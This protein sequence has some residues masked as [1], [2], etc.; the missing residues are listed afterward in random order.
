MQKIIP[1]T[2][3]LSV[4]CILL[5]IPSQSSTAQTGLWSDP[6]PLSEL[7]GEEVTIASAP[8]LAVDH[9]G[10]LH[11]VWHGVTIEVVVD[12]DGNEQPPQNRDWLRYRARRAG[13]WTG[14]QNVF[15]R[16]RPTLGDAFFTQSGGAGMYNPAFTLRGQLLAGNDSHLHLLV[17]NAGRQWYL[18]APLNDE[19]VR[20]L[21]L[22][23][24]WPL[25]EG[26]QSAITISPEGKLYLVINDTPP[27]L[28]TIAD[29]PEDIC[30]D[31][32]YVFFRYS[33]DGGRI[34]SNTENISDD[35][36][37]QVFTPQ[38]KIDT[39][40]RLHVIWEERERERALDPGGQIVYQYSDDAGQRWQAPVRMALTGETV[41]QAAL[42][43]NRLQT[44]MVV[45]Q[46]MQSEAVFYQMSP[47]Y[48]TNW[49][50]PRVLPDVQ[51]VGGSADFNRFSLAADGNG[52]I[53][54][55]M[56]GLPTGSGGTAA[57][58][59][60]LVWDG[61]TWSPPRSIA[62]GAAHPRGPQ[63]VMERGQ[64]LHAVWF[65]SNIHPQS[66]A[67]Q[68]QVWYS[69]LDLA[70][71]EVALLPTLTPDPARLPTATREPI[72]F[73]TL[74]PLDEPLRTQ[75]TLDGPPL[76]ELRGLQAAGL[77]LFGV[78][79][80]LLVVGASYLRLRR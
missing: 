79:L 12:E 75:E 63:L 60:H 46:G 1:I 5:L 55:L 22:F 70:A 69:A 18:K 48:G 28:E 41:G 56:V 16:V 14:T 27:G 58:L 20:R 50:L 8:A 62:T 3:I 21:V 40:N 68:Q 37:V 32:S 23:P 74:V 44:V 24:P 7:D 43:V 10:N 61:Q 66:R 65:T 47:D 77:G 15:D 2:I 64:R 6:L 4:T 67:E 30:T 19:I 33:D 13:V 38:I 11:T 57:Q 52:H 45:Y 31:C 35:D 9:E 26:P 25:S 53:H 73:P 34:W 42:V 39:L 51:S 78:V 80:L 49:A 59:L 17:G 76:W 54:M 72:V 29:L 71:P 36:D